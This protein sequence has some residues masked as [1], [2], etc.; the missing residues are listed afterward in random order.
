ME[1]QRRRVDGRERDIA[2]PPDV[3]QRAGAGVMG[4]RGV[5]RERAPLGDRVGAAGIG[6]QGVRDVDGERVRGVS[7]PLAVGHGGPN[8]VRSRLGEGVRYRGGI[9]A[10]NGRRGAGGAV[11]PVDRPGRGRLRPKAAVEKGQGVRT[12]DRGVRRPVRGDDRGGLVDLEVH[13]RLGDLAEVVG[14]AEADLVVQRV[15][16]DAHLVQ[17]G[18]GDRWVRAESLGIAAVV[19]QVPGVGDGSGVEGGVGREGEAPPL[20]DLVGAEDRGRR[21]GDGIDFVDAGIGHVLAALDGD[22][23]VRRGDRPVSVPRRVAA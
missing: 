5:E 9:A 16:A 12:D 15:V 19:A 2:D 3:G 11:V 18:P 17:V 4:R 22:M 20:G 6:D 1:D 14:H 10:V 13:R 7:G 8:G 23:A 21:R